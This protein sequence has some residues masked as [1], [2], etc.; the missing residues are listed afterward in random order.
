MALSPGDSDV[1]DFKVLPIRSNISDHDMVFFHVNFP[2][3][4]SFTRSITFKRYQKVADV[5]HFCGIEQTL[6]GI[7]SSTMSTR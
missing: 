6:N 1:D 4:Y 7:D 5:S 2:N 3:I